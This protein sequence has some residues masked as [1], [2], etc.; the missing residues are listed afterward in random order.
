M[1]LIL[2]WLCRLIC[3]PMSLCA[4]NNNS[5]NSVKETVPMVIDSREDRAV[6]DQIFRN[7]ATMMV[8]SEAFNRVSLI[9]AAVEVHPVND[10][11]RDLIVF[12][13]QQ[14]MSE[15]LQN[16]IK[17]KKWMSA[18]KG[19]LST[20][21]A[22]K[23]GLVERK[24]MGVVTEEASTHVIVLVILILETAIG[25]ATVAETEIEIG[26]ETRIKV[27]VE[28]K[29]S[30]ALILE[31]T[32][33]IIIMTEIVIE[34]VAEKE[35]ESPAMTAKKRTAHASATEREIVIEIESAIKIEARSKNATVKKTENP[36]KKTR[37]EKET[38]IK[39]RFE[40]E[41]EIGTVKKSTKIRDGTETHPHSTNIRKRQASLTRMTPSATTRKTKRR[42]DTERVAAMAIAI[43]IRHKKL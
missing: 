35:L 31:T 39:K 3:H 21:H 42:K 40:I 26:T 36:K 22:T 6:V 10:P 27:I 18:R 14:V 20:R 8:A 25:N 29:E 30:A 43:T 38:K 2:R 5:S 33:E 17:S 41:I 11:N 9:V 32:D 13:V 24:M 12:L 23:S 7:V 28:G 4:C 37:T 1:G 16:L 15:V 19:V 34:I